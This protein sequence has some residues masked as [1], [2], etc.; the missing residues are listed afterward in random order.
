MFIPLENKPDWR[1]PPFI[2][3]FLILLN[4]S[5]FALWQSGDDVLEENAHQYYFSSGLAEIEL[6]PYM[7]FLKKNTQL[8][9]ATQ[10]YSE[11]TT[12]EI[13]YLYRQLLTDGN[14]VSQLESGEV[15][16]PKNTDFKR[17]N[18]HRTKYKNKLNQV[19][20]Y[21]YGYQPAFPTKEKIL[22]SLFLHANHIHLLGNLFFLFLFGF[23][24]EL[25]IGR[26]LLLFCYITGGIAANLITTV[27]EPSN[28]QWLIGASGS[29]TA[30]AGIYII[31]FGMQKLR[32]FY[33]LVFYF[34]YI[35]AP[36]FIMLP[37]WVIY[38]I[39]HS[40]IDPGTVN[41]ITHLGGL[42]YGIIVGSLIRQFLPRSVEAHKNSTIKEELDRQFQQGMTYISKTEFEK[43]HDVFE[44]LLENS[45]ENINVLKQLFFIA[46]IQSDHPAMKDFTCRL[47]SLPLAGKEDLRIK[48]QI[49][50]DY[51][52]ST[53]GSPELSLE[54][55]SQACLRLCSS[56]NNIEAEKTLKSII[57]SNP[58]YEKLPQLLYS[59]VNNLY[60]RGNL[61]KE[62]FFLNQLLTEYS[63]SHEA[64]NAKIILKQL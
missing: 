7:V 8:P 31:L 11:L 63:G 53:E 6:P 5:G 35:R 56:G 12:N 50:I 61:N 25:A 42:A 58:G 44:N 13:S 47:L 22:G 33:T 29:I 18:K 15:I 54:M 2:T 60:K 23:V 41:T 1:H 32:F 43:A 14:F 27:L 46:K 48:N 57:S 36:A 9:F 20:R 21:K 34:D 30:L 19:T 17:W 59:I 28:A 55:M 38:E 49:F 26:T 24:L 45:P 16:T 40:I 3:L 4:L 62:N 51:L 39:L 52:N 64:A 10:H 37:V